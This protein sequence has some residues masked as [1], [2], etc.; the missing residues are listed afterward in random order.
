MSCW[1]VLV[2][3]CHNGS[4][5]LS[6]LHLSCTSLYII[7]VK[8]KQRPNWQIKLKK[9]SSVL[10]WTK[11][12]GWCQGTESHKMRCRE[13]DTGATSRV[14]STTPRSALPLFTSHQARTDSTPTASNFIT[15]SEKNTGSG[16]Q[17]DIQTRTVI[18]E[19]KGRDTRGVQRK[20]M[21][22]AVFDLAQWHNILRTWNKEYSA[23]RC[24]AVHRDELKG[25]FDGGNR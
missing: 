21:F 11:L 4:L 7:R 13:W 25:S 2:H 12:V 3:S 10:L 23:R 5:C 22:K 14:G 16:V 8:L 1:S 6:M 9:G 18:S 17:W 15:C 20:T 19:L 24:S